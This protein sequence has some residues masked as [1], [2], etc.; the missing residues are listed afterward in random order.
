M[1][2]HL[3]ASIT[4]SFSLVVIFA[5]VL[6]QPEDTSRL[7]TRA[8]AGNSVLP[9][10]EPT[11]RSSPPPPPL[12]PGAP[13]IEPIARSGPVPPGPQTRDAETL[14]TNGSEAME[15]H[16][17]APEGQTRRAEGGTT[18]LAA[19]SR[20]PSG[21]IMIPHADAPS[22]AP[23]AHGDAEERPPHD[24]F[25][26]AKEGETLRDVA[27]RVYGSPDRVDHLWQLNRDLIGRDDVVLSSG[28][29]LRTP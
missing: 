22:A 24:P 2:Q 23:V 17:P 19:G 14:P 1:D 29:L 12:T 25:T 27:L 16:R 5:I 18:P 21:I 15:L 6:Y 8:E 9:K 28:T 4:L 13:L 10:A 7:T 11:I 20:S 26:L 3:G